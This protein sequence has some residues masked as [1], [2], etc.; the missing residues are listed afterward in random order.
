MGVP[1]LIQQAYNFF[2]L[3]TLNKYTDINFRLF[4]LTLK[5]PYTI[6]GKK[7]GDSAG[8]LNQYFQVKYDHQLSSATFR[9]ALRSA[10][11]R[12]G[13]RLCLHPKH[14]YDARNVILE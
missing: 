6:C 3:H 2:E 5:E 13:K 10:Y 11:L 1:F 14:P 7:G 9:D 8:C 4:S 12:A